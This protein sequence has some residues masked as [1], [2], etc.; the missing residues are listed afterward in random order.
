MRVLLKNFKD[1]LDDSISL[2][3]RGLF[4]TIVFLK[5]EDSKITLAKV[6]AKVSFRKHKDSLILLH[7]KGFI[8]WSG[9]KLAKKSLEEKEL[10]PK[11]VEVIDFMNSLYKTSFGY[12]TESHYKS[13]LRLIEKHD[14]DD[15]KRVISN[16]FVEWKD[17]SFMSKYLNPST[18]FRQSK[19]PKYLEEV[20]MTKKGERFLQSLKT[21]LKDGDSINIGNCDTLIDNESYFIEISYLS[22][23]GKCDSREV[24]HKSGKD[25]KR[26]LKIQVKTIDFGGW[27]EFEYRYKSE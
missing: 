18:I 12:T 7:E 8:D 3:S 25:I 16:R 19:F 22:R 26:S 14:T 5:E 17:D 1:L 13:L 15:I 4:L 20:N 21:N 9:Y 2:E 6:K 10:N 27:L 11:V 24:I 23:E